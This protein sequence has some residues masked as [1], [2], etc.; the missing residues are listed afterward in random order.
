VLS[1]LRA[2]LP[3]CLGQQNRNPEP[4]SADC[5]QSR[6]GP[7]TESASQQARS[8]RSE[9][10]QAW[11]RPSSPPTAS[12]SFAGSL[13]AVPGHMPDCVCAALSEQTS[14]Q[15]VHA[16]AK[17]HASILIIAPPSIRRKIKSK[18]QIVIQDST[19]GSVSPVKSSGSLE[20]IIS[21]G[22]FFQ[23]SQAARSSTRVFCSSSAR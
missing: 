19:V 7:R 17:N 10:G 4:S 15:C 14:P 22:M 1:T 6:I 9:Q 21:L 3:C 23:W 2:A 12:R 11:L 16:P 20:K 5:A 13:S 8:N 18:G